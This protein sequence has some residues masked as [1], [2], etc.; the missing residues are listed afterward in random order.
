MSAAGL[1]ASSIKPL[2]CSW[3]SATLEVYVDGVLVGSAQS[4]QKKMAQIGCPKCRCYSK[5]ELKVRTALMMGR[6]GGEGMV[7]EFSQANL[8]K[9]SCGGKIDQSLCADKKTSL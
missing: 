9:G 1:G 4:H 2:A 5:R 3:L 7:A 8:L 6:R